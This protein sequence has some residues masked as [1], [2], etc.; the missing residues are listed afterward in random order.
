MCANF[1]VKPTTSIF[2]TQICPKIQSGLEIE[3]TNVG[4]RISIL[5][6]PS[7]P[8]LDLGFESQKTNVGMKISLV[9]IRCVPIFRQNGQ[10]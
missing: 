4:I 1:Q 2:S 3:K 5:E 6:I 9:E 10:L 7:L 8:K